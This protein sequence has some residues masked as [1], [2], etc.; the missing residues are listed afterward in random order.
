MSQYDIQS[1]IELLASRLKE[2]LPLMISKSQS[3]FLLG[4]LL[5][6]NV[7]LATDLVN[8]YNTHSITPRGMLKVDLRKAFDTVRW[9]FI[10][11]SLRAIAIPESFIRLISEC[12]STA[13]FSVTVNGV[14]D[15]FF[16]STKGIRQGDPL[17]P[18]LFVLAMEC[19]SRLLQSRYDSGNIGYHPKTEQLKLSHLMFADD[20]IVFFDG[21]SN[22]LHGISECLDDFASWSGLHMNTSKTEIF[23]AGLQQPDSLAIASYSFPSGTLPIRYLG[24]PLMSRKLKISEYAPLTNRLSACFHSWSAKLLSF[25]GHLQL[26]KTV[27]FGIVNFWT[28][29]FILP[30]GCIKSIESLCSRFLWSGSLEK[31]GIAKIS[32]STVC[33]PKNEGGLGLRSFLVWNQVLCLKFIWILL[34]KSPSLWADWHWHI[35]LTNKSFWTIEA[36]SNDSWDRKRLLKLRPLALQFCKMSLGNGQL[37]SFW[38]DNWSPLGQLINHIG[39]L[40]PRTLRIRS[41]AVVADAIVNSTWSLPHPRSAQEVELHAHLTTIPLPLHTD[42]DDTYE[43]VAGD[44]PGCGFI[45]STTWEVLRPRDQVKDWVDVVWF[46]G[47]VPKHAFTMWTATWD[48]LPTRERLAAWGMPIAT[49]CPLCARGNETRDHLLL[50]CEYSLQVW[51]EVFIRCTAPST[52]FTTWS[53]LLSWIRAAGSKELKLLRKVAT[54][55]FVFHIWKQRNN[56][57][58]NQLSIPSSSVFAGLDREVRNIISAKRK[59]KMFSNL[60]SLWFR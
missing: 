58:H 42:I 38:Y 30:K 19:L 1:Y 59:R 27:I 16:K 52:M 6:E 51:R 7:L 43:W 60:M 18:Y 49:T 2:I 48:R 31:K 13:S 45:A 40:G 36:A 35:H 11:A 23:T 33:F 44:S 53:E 39:P 26:L 50:S 17:S 15:G 32:W 8:G 10:L 29:A 4:R 12:L 55:A 3:A 47:S 41:N 46:K 57:V 54:Q 21:S 14:S 28:S 25:T 20:V 22:S 37:A 24:L 9:D 56:L 5:A 34:S